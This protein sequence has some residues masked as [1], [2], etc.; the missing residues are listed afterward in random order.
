[1]QIYGT[2]HSGACE[3]QRLLQIF[4]FEIRVFR[5]QFPAVGISRENLH[6][7]PHRDSHSADARMAAHLAWFNSDPVKGRPQCHTSI[8]PRTATLLVVA[9]ATIRAENLSKIYRSGETDLAIFRDLQL[10]VQNGESL[11]LT[12]ESGAGKSTLLH[13]LGALDNPTSGTVY[14]G[15][16]DVTHLG[17][18]ELAL[19]RNR[20]IGFVWQSHHL[21]PEFT[22]A[23]NAAMPLLIR[24]ES[25]SAARTRALDLL[26]EV[27]LKDRAHHRAGELSGGE[28]QRV[29][30][31]RA[32]TGRPSVLLADEPTGNLD[33]RT[34]EKIFGLLQD[35]HRAHGLT[36]VIVTH[37]PAFAARCD[38]AL[39]IEAGGL[40]PA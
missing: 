25:Q 33:P 27:G 16:T 36:S 4:L 21:L 7:A 20:T 29:A 31:A 1:M 8:I 32:L 40:V 2:V 30:L 15:A 17:D 38:R 34:G 10:A 35:L 3:G 28:Q 13:L 39:R 37:N 12:G 23:E 9:D 6:H 18:N 5:E 26:A 22:A 14:Y 24:G 19:F 11:A